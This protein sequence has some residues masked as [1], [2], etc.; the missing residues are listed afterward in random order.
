MSCEGSGS[1]LALSER[2]SARVTADTMCH[3]AGGC[4]SPAAVR[5]ESP[6]MAPKVGGWVADRAFGQ[7]IVV[8][9]ELYWGHVSLWPLMTQQC[10]EMK[11]QQLY[12]TVPSILSRKSCR[13]VGIDLPHLVPGSHG[14]ALGRQIIFLFQK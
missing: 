7:G 3:T 2:G 5:T 13:N 8:V 10:L 9:K 6:I 12:S 11:D 14:H 4:E 1:N